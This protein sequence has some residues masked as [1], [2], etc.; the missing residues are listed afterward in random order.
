MDL[1]ILLQGMSRDGVL[2]ANLV[3]ILIK[4]SGASVAAD[5]YAHTYVTVT[6]SVLAR[7]LSLVGHSLLGGKTEAEEHK[8]SFV[9]RSGGLLNDIISTAL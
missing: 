8:S 1:Q 9:P 6:L 2:L 7:R 3:G 4:R 5:N